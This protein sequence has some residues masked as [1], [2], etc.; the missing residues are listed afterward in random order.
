MLVAA[1]EE[2]KRDLQKDNLANRFRN[3]NDEEEEKESK[4]RKR[5]ASRSKS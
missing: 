3:A 1:N 4:G 2:I 5:I